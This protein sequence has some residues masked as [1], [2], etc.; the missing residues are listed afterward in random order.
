MI[1]VYDYLINVF[2]Y[3]IVCD[4]YRKNKLGQCFNTYV[5]II[6]RFNRKFHAGVF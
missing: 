1:M 4:F 3:S 6:H 2:S 5:Y